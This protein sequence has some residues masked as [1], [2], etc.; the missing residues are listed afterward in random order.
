[1]AGYLPPSFEVSIPVAQSGE[2][3]RDR[4]I[5]RRRRIRTVSGGT[6]LGRFIPVVSTLAPVLGPYLF[7]DGAD[8]GARPILRAAT[9]PA[10]QGDEYYG[11]N[12]FAGLRGNAAVVESSRRSHDA[13]TQR[14]LWNVSTELTGVVYPI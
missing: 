5:Q 12:G 13:K 1:M 7:P 6:D 11:P 3:Q 8:F 10:V 9:D 2:P 4:K 14:R